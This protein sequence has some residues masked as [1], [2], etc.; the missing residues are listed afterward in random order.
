M[1]GVKER[2]AKPF[3]GRDRNFSVF[4]SALALAIVVMGSLIVALLQWSGSEVDRMARSRDQSTALAVLS[5]SVEQVSHSMEAGATSPELLRRI[6]RFPNDID[7]IDEYVGRRFAGYAGLDETYILSSQG[8]ALYAMREHKRALPE[9]YIAVEEFATP[10]IRRV[11]EARFGA[12]HQSGG[13]AARYPMIADIEV[14]RGRPAIISVKPVLTGQE[15]PDEQLGNRPMIVGVAFLD[16]AY[17]ERLAQQF[18]LAGVHYQ[19]APSTSPREISRPLKSKNGTT[20]GYLIWRPFAPGGQVVTA[21]APVLLLVVLLAAM[22]VYT[23]ASRL[24]RR[25]RDLETSRSLAQHQAM[26]DALTGLANRSM[27]EARLE[28]ALQYCRRSCSSLALIYIDLDRFKQINDTL[29]HPAG[30]ELI[31]QVAQR[32][33]LEVRDYDIVARLGGDEFAIVIVAPQD[34]GA[35]DSICGRIVDELGRPFELFGA[36]AYIGASLGVVCSPEDGTERT[37]L[38]RRVDIALYAAKAEGRSRHLFFTPAMDA[39][40]REKEDITRELRTALIE[41]STQLVVHY[42]PMYSA[43]TG[44]ITAVE[45]L[46]RWQ[47]PQWGLIGP[48]RF[49]QQAEESGLIDALGAFVLGRAMADARAWPGLRISVNVSPAQMQRPDF[50]NAVRTMLDEASLEPHRLELELTETALMGS[51]GAVARVIAQLRQMGVSCALDDFGTGY[52][53]LSHIRDMA[54]D[55]V[56]IDKSFVQSIE[57]AQGAGLVEAIVN[58]AR[59]NGLQLTAEGVETEAQLRYLRELGCHEL[60][61]FVLSRPLPARELAGLLSQGGRAINPAFVQAGIGDWIV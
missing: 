19:I 15:R 49:I 47:H 2:R 3:A 55:R 1:A 50:P 40:V 20:I 21:L 18:G 16:G 24:S 43:R 37:E 29:G 33:L 26:H 13:T 9:T 35:I 57:T 46:L 39:D 52:S 12:P 59:V 60:Q 28:H 31:R 17:F 6:E 56:K 41:D 32:L 45:A 54:V 14:V 22:V 7:L 44:E 61:G 10:L 42:Q 38:I 23:L 4:A 53:S 58:L 25:T 27:F 11:D 8:K 36:K 48:G 5:Q 34:R 51:S 30:D